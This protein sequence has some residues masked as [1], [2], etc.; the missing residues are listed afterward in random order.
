MSESEQAEPTI[1][2]VSVREAIGR[3]QPERELRVLTYNVR[4]LKDDRA[5]VARIVGAARPDVV[6]FQEA[7][8][9]PFW[10][11]R[12][13]RL[14]RD[15][16]LLFVSGG[17]PAAGNMLAAAARV[18]VYGTLDTAL[19]PTAGLGRRGVATALL[20]LG[21]VRFAVIGMHGGL[22]AHERE[23]H[24]DEILVVSDW[25]RAAGAVAVVL[26]GDLN[27]APD[28]REWRRLS[29]GFADAYA[30]APVGTELT[31]PAKQPRHRIDV[32]WAQPPIDVLGAG[33]FDHRD[34]PRASDHRP[35]LAVLRLPEPQGG[36]PG[37]GE[38]QIT[39]PLSG[40]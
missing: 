18:S 11:E 32:V 28:R 35:V 36:R 7:P 26:A 5:A 8:T 9:G 14:A 20:G 3:A 33:V 19:S 37:R 30:A 2:P 1:G 29:A 4:G 27:S 17:R 16:D 38:T 25:M 34:V 10:R 6:C 13:S 12:C 24:G 23:R 21:G 39:A 40:S 22:A 15:C 31:F